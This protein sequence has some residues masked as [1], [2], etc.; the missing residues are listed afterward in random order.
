MHC[1]NGIKVDSKKETKD[2]LHKTPPKIDVHCFN[3][4]KE[5]LIMENGFFHL[6]H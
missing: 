2:L 6:N 4:M 3:G 5:D 1:F